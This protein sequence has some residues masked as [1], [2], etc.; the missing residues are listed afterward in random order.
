MDWAEVARVMP[1][2][3]MRHGLRRA[4][5]MREVSRMMGEMGLDGSLVEAIAARHESFADRRADDPGDTDPP[6]SP[7]AS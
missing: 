2:R 6:T 7:H 5:E 1:S 4:A 3:V